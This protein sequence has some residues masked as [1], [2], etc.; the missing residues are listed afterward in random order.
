LGDINV[1]LIKTVRGR[2]I[3]LV[4]DT[5]LPRPYSRLHV[6]QGT[7]G[8]FQKWPERI[9]VEGRSPAHEWEPLERYYP[10]FEHPLWRSEKIKAMS[11][12]HGGMDYLESYRLIECL[13][14]GEPTDM[15]VYDAA[16]WSAIA[17]LTERSVV[18]HSQ[19]VDVPDFT[20][21]RWQS[22]APLGIVPA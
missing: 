5:N 22:R 11:G 16:A 14:R 12:G 9:H 3:Y 15:D 19:P 21:G 2:T 1:T 18:R 6:V 17:E 8:V 7:R 4:H 13:R 20:R 10:E